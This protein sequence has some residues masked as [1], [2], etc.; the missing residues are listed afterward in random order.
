MLGH[1]VTELFGRQAHAIAVA[2][3]IQF[4]ILFVDRGANL[5]FFVLKVAADSIELVVHKLHV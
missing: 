1:C 2:V 3:Y 5:L 4:L